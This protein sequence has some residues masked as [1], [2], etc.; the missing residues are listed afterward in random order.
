VTKR[1]IPEDSPS[2]GPLQK[3]ENLKEEILS[4]VLIEKA[5]VK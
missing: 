1:N 4:S 3:P 5:N 2:T